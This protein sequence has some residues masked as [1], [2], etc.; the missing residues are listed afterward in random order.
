MDRIELVKKVK[1][2]DGL[3]YV[4]IL[5]TDDFGQKTVRVPISVFDESKIS[6]LSKYGIRILPNY[7]FAMSILLNKLAD[8]MPMEDATHIIGIVRDKN[9]LVFNGY[10]S[11]DM[12][13]VKNHF[14]S[15]DGYLAKFNKLLIQSEP[16][17]YL[18]SATMAAPIMTIMNQKYNYDLHSYIIKYYRGK[19]NR[20][21]N[22]Q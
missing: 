2:A 9:R 11:N 1:S 6:Q 15:F 18:L 12:F 5:V 14:S 21:D 4:D 8:E 22:M 10:T 7:K 16:L 20:Q 13:T 19:F 3:V 17:Q